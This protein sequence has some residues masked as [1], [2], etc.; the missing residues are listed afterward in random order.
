M[1]STEK[2]TIRPMHMIYPS[3]LSD[4]SELFSIAHQTNVTR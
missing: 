4:V 2:I 3:Y 1:G